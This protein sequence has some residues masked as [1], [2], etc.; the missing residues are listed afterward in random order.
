M[1][2]NI[3]SLPGPQYQSR[4]GNR[5]RQLRMGKAGPDMCRHVVITLTGVGVVRISIRDKT[6]EKVLKI[7]MY[8]GICILGDRQRS[9][10]VGDK[11]M[12]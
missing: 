12:A 5:Y 10:G 11:N 3:N 6:R 1:F 4:I 8:P 7:I 2:P 9:A